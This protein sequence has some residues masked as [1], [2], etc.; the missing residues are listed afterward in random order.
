MSANSLQPLL[1]ICPT[2]PARAS[3]VAYPTGG[4]DAL[5][6]TQPLLCEALHS[7]NKLRVAIVTET[8]PPEVN[9]V[10]L[11]IAAMVHALASRGHQV[12]VVRLYQGAEKEPIAAP[13]G[14]ETFLRRGV[15]LPWY[16]IVRVGFPARGGLLRQ[17]KNNPPDVIYIATE[18][19]LGWSAAKVARGLGIPALSGFH[20][21]FDQY[22][23]HYGLSALRG[24]VE[25]YLRHFHNLTNGTIVATEE[26][27]GE[28]EEKGFHRV[29]VLPRGVDTQLFNPARRSFSLRKYWG[30]TEDSLVALYVGRLAAEKSLDV[31]ISSYRS[32][33]A[34]NPGVRLVMVG[35]G[36]LRTD[37]AEVPDLIL[38][39]TQ[40]GEALAAHFASA[41]IFLF[42]S[43]TETFGNVV[44]EAMASGLAV[45]AYDYA[46]ARAHMRHG[47]NGLQVP[48]AN[49]ERF[50][51]AAESLV[52]HPET[53]ITLAKD[54]RAATLPLDSHRIYDALETVLFEAVKKGGL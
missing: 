23:T 4:Q 18:G 26:L 13:F 9:G 52:R 35:D 48:Y 33:Q 14:I 39:G 50:H 31:V 54:A 8:F 41:D 51:E 1:P 25:T 43:L 37:L 49:V 17:W 45:V 36:P 10:A 32:M 19:P 27:K 24:I 46:A 21:R 5:A 47:Y 3:F 7:A 34:M 40:H 6:L 22:T 28:L 42:P 29:R 38:C 2:H 53:R 12:Q 11:R 16:N 20:T 15:A 44:L 30:A